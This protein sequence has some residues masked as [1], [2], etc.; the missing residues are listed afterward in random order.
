MKCKESRGQ[1]VLPV[2]YK[3]KP[4]DVRH[5]QGSFGKAFES[6][7]DKFEEEV[8]QQGPLALRKAVDLGVFESDKFDGREGELVNKLAEIILRQQQNDFPP[9]LPTDLVGIEDRVAEVMKLVDIACPDTRIIGIWGMGG[10][11]RAIAHPEGTQPWLWSR[12]WGEEAMAVLRSEENEY[13]E[14]L[15]LDKNGSS[16][17]IER[18][19]FKRLPKLKFLH[20][21]AVG[22]AGHLEE[23]LCELRWLKWESCPHSFKATSVHLKKLLV[24]DL[25]GGNIHENWDGWGSIK[26]E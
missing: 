16:K 1:I 7:K 24:F 9:S 15:R 19:S 2:L 20:V 18:E 6:C 8:K 13:I 5:L 21:S 10:I 3:V 14:A 23:S 17:F 26:M 22:F 4:K 25:S 12:L 11:G